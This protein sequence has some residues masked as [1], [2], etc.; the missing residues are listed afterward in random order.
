MK[1]LKWF[2]CLCIG[3][4]P[5]EETKS[6][7]HETTEQNDVYP[8]FFIAFWWVASINDSI[9]LAPRNDK[10]WIALSKAMCS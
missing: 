8:I 1:N 2:S 5:S 6:E 3:L 4:S 9:A 10:D 7:I